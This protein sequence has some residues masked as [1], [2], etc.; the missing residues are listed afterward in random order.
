MVSTRFEHTVETAKPFDQA[1][2]AVEQAAQR[3]GFRVLYVHDVAADLAEKGFRREP[4]KIVEICNASYA[5]QV[6][7]RDVRMALMLPCPIAVYQQGGRV[8]IS[9]MLPEII[10]RLCPEAGLEGLAQQVQKQVVEIVN[11]AAH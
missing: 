2:A 5:S 6:L 9:T 10:A 7:D 1:V 8:N 4:L 3:H 11:E